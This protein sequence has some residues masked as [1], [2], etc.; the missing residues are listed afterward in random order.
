MKKKINIIISAAIVALM[1]V[2]CKPTEKNYQKA[3]DAALAKRQQAAEEQMRPAS[4]LLID[5]GP[6]R[7]IVGNDTIYVLNEILRLP[8]GNKL[9]GRVA[10]AVGVFKMD[11]NAKASA[12]DLTS[13]GYPAAT[14]AK[15]R[16]GHFYTI[17]T[18][19]QNLD[20]LRFESRKFKEKFPGYPFVGLPGAPVLILF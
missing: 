4:G 9:P 2:G 14:V 19:S 13:Q 1:F 5:E 3:Y 12:S 18:T 6:Q 7:R 10:M 16:E 15:G 11:T 8:D 20:S 17:A